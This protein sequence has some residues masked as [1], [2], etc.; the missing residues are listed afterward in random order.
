MIDSF[1][2]K[3]EKASKLAKI[4]IEYKNDFEVLVYNP[5]YQMFNRRNEISVTI[6]Y[7]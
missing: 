4:N 6:N 1:L 3:T 5:P 7:K 2:L